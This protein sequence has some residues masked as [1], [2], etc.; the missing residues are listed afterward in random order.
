MARRCRRGDHDLDLTPWSG[1]GIVA[2]MVLVA[3][4]ITATSIAATP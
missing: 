3:V 1:N 4:S 2:V